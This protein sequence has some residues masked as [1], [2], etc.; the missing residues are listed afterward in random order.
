VGTEL[1]PQFIQDNNEVEEWRHACAIM[2]ADFPEQWKDLTEVLINF[3]FFKDQVV[4]PGGGLSLVSHFL[5][6]DFRKK[7][8][9]DKKTFP[10]KVIVDGVELDVRTHEVDCYKNKIALE[11]EWNNKD[12][13]FQRDLDNFRRLFDLRAV[14][15]G[16]I[17][18]RAAE[19]QEI[20]DEL[21]DEDGDSIGRKYG[22]STTHMDAGAGSEGSAIAPGSS[23]VILDQLL[24]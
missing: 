3:R 16:I 22:N 10:T 12:P 5:D 4:I 21:Y 18:T 17:I 13:F 6:R 15:V 1:L 7:K 24:P 19:L 9:W 23:L 11:I 2:A 20:F 14:S 8:G